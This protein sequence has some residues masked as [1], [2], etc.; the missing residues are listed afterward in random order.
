[1][2][3]LFVF[4]WMLSL[5]LKPDVENTAYPPIFI[6]RSPTLDSFRQILDGS[7]IGRYTMNSAVVAGG[8]TLIALILGVPAGYGIAKSQ[9][10]GML[11]FVLIARMTPALSYLIPWFIMFRAIGLNN[12]LTALVITHLVIGLPV[13]IWVMVG[14]FDG[15]PRDLEEAAAVDGASPWQ[16]FW[17]VA[18]PL[19]RPGIVVASLLAFIFSW[20]NFIFAVVLA[21]RETRTL[22]VL[23]FNTLTFERLAFGPL[24]A[25]AI[26]VT[27]P[28]LIVT[29]LVQ[30]QIVVGMTAGAVKS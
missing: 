22:P 15:L 27:L 20:N 1:M 30:R 28:V 4:L 24:A 7:P 16:A 18:L 12:T 23:V 8:S 9:Q 21:G 5:A 11:G 2:P 3:A 19:G 6:P 29:V 10:R 14:F 25:A 13:V 17:H 26:L